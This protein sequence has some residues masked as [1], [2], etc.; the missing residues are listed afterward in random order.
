PEDVERVKALGWPSLGITREPRRFYPQ[1]EL[2]A[3]LIGLV[4]TD[5]QGL[6]GLELSFENELSGDPTTRLGFRDAR[7]RKLLTGRLDE[8]AGRQRATRT[9]TIDRHLQ[10]VTER[11][12]AEAVDASRAVAGMAVMMDPRTGEILALANAP[13]F[14]PN[15]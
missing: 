3:H 10:H 1:R 9:L 12:W 8:A 6:D 2:A 14:N 15:S 11:A 5:G 7:G 4:G 13:R